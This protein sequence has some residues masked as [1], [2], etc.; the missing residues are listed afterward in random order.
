MFC[1]WFLPQDLFLQDPPGFCPFEK[2]CLFGWTL[3]KDIGSEKQKR[4]MVNII[5]LKKVNTPNPL[6]PVKGHEK[7][8]HKVSP[9][10]LARQKAVKLW[11]SQWWQWRRN[12]ETAISTALATP[13]STA[14]C[15]VDQKNLILT[16]GGEFSVQP[17][18]I[19][20][21]KK[22]YATLAFLTKSQF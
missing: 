18:D 20:I 19:Y 5:H 17:N 16:S 22:E 8:C 14:P 9:T 6:C 4:S 11:D 7:N 12:H 1:Y 3:Q 2:V 21:S 15:R 10:V 13:S